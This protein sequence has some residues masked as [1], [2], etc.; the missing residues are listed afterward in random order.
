MKAFDCDDRVSIGDGILR[1]HEQHP[2]C[3]TQWWIGEYVDKRGIVSI[4][5]QAPD[6]SFPKGYTRLDAVL[7]GKLAIRTWKAQLG[8][9]LVRKA[10]RELLDAQ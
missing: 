10:C 2:V 1:L 6:R 8:D 5:R 4:L 3:N 9:R 7:A